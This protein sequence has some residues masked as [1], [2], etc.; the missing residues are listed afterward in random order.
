MYCGIVGLP[1][2]GKST[3]FNALTKTSIAQAANYPF[4]TIEPNIGI[5]H[6][7]DERLQNLAKIAKSQKIITSYIEF[8]D[9]AGLVEGASKGEG[10]GNQFLSN[11]RNVNVIVQ[12]V[13]CFDD[14]NILHVHGKVDPKYDIEIINTELKLADLESVQKKITSSEKKA[15]ISKNAETIEDLEIL[16]ECKNTLLADEM[17]CIKFN[18][19]KMSNMKK[20]GLLTSKPIIYVANVSEDCLSTGNAWSESIKEYSNDVILVSANVEEMIANIEE[21]QEAEEYMNQLGI[22]ASGLSRIANACQEALGLQ[23]FYTIGEKEARSWQFKKG[24]LAP[25]AAGLI[26]TDFEKGFIRAEVISYD[27]YIQ[28]GE[29]GAKANGKMKLQGKDYVMQ[30]GDI[31]HFR[32]NV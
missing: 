18:E 27:D 25:A 20:F 23:T 14:K 17:I 9:I 19:I 1:N 4:C 11:I 12:L 7:Y 6:I 29:Q 3:L 30:D 26:H 16:N 31:V 28:Y 8:V 15:R 32:F 2:V 21:P 24:T 5:A 13:R 10:L 22:K